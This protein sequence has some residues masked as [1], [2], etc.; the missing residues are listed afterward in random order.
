MIRGSA[1][2]TAFRQG[3][4]FWHLYTDGGKME[5]VFARPEDFIFGI[6]L[7]GICSAAFPACRILTFA[8][9][10][11]HIHLI[12]AGPEQDVRAFFDLFRRRLQRYLSSEKRYCTLDRFD[13]ELYRIP[14]VRGLRNEIVYVNRNGYVV[15]PDCT[16]FSYWWSAG[17]FYFNPLAWMLPSQP[18]AS[19]TLR[20]RRTMCH[21]REAE[22]PA[23][24][25][26]FAGFDP[27]Q[28]SDRSTLLLASS[29]C[30]IREGEGYFRDAHQ[31]FQ[32]LGRNLE[33]DSEV[34]RRL[35]D[36]IFLTDD[37]LYGAVCALCSRDYGQA[38]PHLISGGQKVE[39]AKR[40]HFEYNASNK[41]ILRILK[42]EP[43]VVQTLFPS[44][45]TP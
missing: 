15:H 45:K 4:P 26:V 1:C 3:G 11:N 37:E 12:L 33:A 18:F 25:Q 39:M 28:G 2:E 34:A 6:T 21:C 23:K 29:F 19:L 5:I 7:L 8:L 9:M 14:D 22:L 13:P 44:S 30:A 36:R 24:Y 38:N 16:P 10:S 40:M 17:I 43:S 41:Q 42:L 35:G 31:Y 27:R 32:R 20:E